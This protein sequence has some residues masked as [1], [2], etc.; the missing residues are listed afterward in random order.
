MKD[1]R[2]PAVSAI[3]IFLDARAFIA[4]AIESVLAQTFPSWELLLVDDG[5]SDGSREIADAY[6]RRHPHRIRTLQHDDHVNRG[7]SAARNLGL[8]HARGRYVGFLDADDKWPP[9]KL[10][11]LVPALDQDNR[12]SVLFGAI[13]FFGELAGTRR[14]ATPS[15]ELGVPLEP[16]V[17]LRETLLGHPPLLTTLGNPLIRR[18][19]LL[20]VGGLDEEFQGLAEDAVAWCK[21]AL[22]FRF[23]AIGETALEYRRHGA[24]SGV[25]DERSGALASG[26]A[27]FARWLHGYVLSQPLKIR[28]WAQPIAA[29]HLFRS[30]VLAAWLTCPDDPVRRRMRLVRTWRDLT[31]SH[32]GAL[33]SRRRFR[34]ALQLA[35]GLRS[36][37]LRGL[38]EPELDLR[39]QVS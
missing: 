7:M 21:L 11:L 39:R 1:C 35:G 13:E 37:A 26:R 16:S 24:A 6:A 36:G 32:P 14:I 5:S 31:R 34:L 9:Q 3:V 23:A 4:E 25:V 10:E 19:A 15:V 27:R 12:L 2:P 30:V 22:R 20:E 29:E 17:V 38:Q 28:A 18:R 8:Q 33:T